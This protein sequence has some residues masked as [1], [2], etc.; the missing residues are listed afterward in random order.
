MEGTINVDNNYAGMSLGMGILSIFIPVL[1]FIFGII[2]IV[3]ANKTIKELN[4]SNE[5]GYGVAIAGLICS[6]IG[7]AMFPFE[8]IGILAFVNY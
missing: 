4:N 5:K 3:L 6:I 1:G 2:G 7:I 8:V